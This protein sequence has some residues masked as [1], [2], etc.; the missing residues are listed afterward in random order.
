MKQTKR[1]VSIVA[2]L[3]ILVLSFC[4]CSSQNAA[5]PGVRPEFKE[6][7][8]SYEGFF[9]EYCSFMDRYTKS[10]NPLGMMNEYLN[11]LSRY[12]TML[13]KFSAIAN[14]DMNEAEA[15]YYQRAYERIMRKISGYV[16]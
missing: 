9:D 7:V 15:L 2:V 10:E 3:A 8:D 6:A 5:P 16:S 12:Q 13:Q 11:F 14:T 4:S 1:V